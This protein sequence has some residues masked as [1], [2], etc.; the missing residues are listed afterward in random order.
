[1]K[2]IF[3]SLNKLGY[4]IIY[5]ETIKEY[6]E[7]LKSNENF[8]YDDIIDLLEWF[9]YVR[10]SNKSVAQEEVKKIENAASKKYRQKSKIEA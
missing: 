7:R 5:G 8:E 1:M 9:Q 4:P 3:S 6:L 10:Y 2:K